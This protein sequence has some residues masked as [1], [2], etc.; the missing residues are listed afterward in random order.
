MVRNAPKYTFTGLTLADIH[1]TSNSFTYDNKVYKVSEFAGQPGNSSLY[2][3]YI[4]NPEDGHFLYVSYAVFSESY[5]KSATDTTHV[6]FYHI[7]IID[8]TNNIYFTIKVNVPTGFDD[9]AIFMTL[10]YVTYD[11]LG[12]PK[13][14]AVSI[15]AIV[16]SEGGNLYIPQYELSMLPSG[17]YTFTM[18]LAP[19][20]KVSYTASRLNNISSAAATYA[21]DHEG[22]YFPPSSV[23]P[24]QIDLVFTVEVDSNAISTTN[25][26]GMGTSSTETVKA[27]YFGA[28]ATITQKNTEAEVGVNLVNLVSS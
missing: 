23:V 15:Y 27:T 2:M 3:N 25:L 28:A 21:D 18:E 19:G 11:T 1:S 14:N 20:Y 4:G 26:W 24:I 22:A 10:N 17:Y 9:D 12:N 16:D 7:S 6:D 8:L 5:L 13:E